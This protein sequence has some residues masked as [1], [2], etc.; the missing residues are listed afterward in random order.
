M[1]RILCGVHVLVQRQLLLL[2]KQLDQR[3]LGI[4]GKFTAELMS[5]MKKKLS[6]KSHFIAQLWRNKCGTC[7]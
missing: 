7:G 1:E 6:N 3:F 4:K 2:L 5:Y